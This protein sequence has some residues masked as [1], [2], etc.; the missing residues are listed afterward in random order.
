MDLQMPI[1]DGYEATVALR[2]L[3]AAGKLPDAPI[4]AI[5]A[6]DRPEDKKRCIDVGMVDHL[7]KPINESKLKASISKHLKEAFNAT[8]K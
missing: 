8:S 3:M 6:N 7:S 2:N 1:M 4:I 5:S